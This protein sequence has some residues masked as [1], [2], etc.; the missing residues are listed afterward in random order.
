MYLLSCSLFLVFLFKQKTA[1]E[2]RSSDWSSDV[3]SSDRLWSCASCHGAQGEGHDD[4]PRLAGL[5]DGYIA[6]QL[7]D[8]TAGKRDNDTM[9]MVARQLNPAEMEDIGRYYGSLPTTSTARPVLGGDMA[10]RGQQDL[11]GDGKKSRRAGVW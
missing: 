2:M 10:A 1:Y 6:K 3:C 7:A 5:P 11:E 8:F 4:I 9:T